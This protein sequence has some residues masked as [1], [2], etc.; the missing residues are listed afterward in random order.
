M[1]SHNPYHIGGGDAN[2][3]TILAP[4]SLGKNTPNLFGT[5]GSY[6]AIAKVTVPRYERHG[7][8]DDIDLGTATVYVG[9]QTDTLSANDNAQRY[10]HVIQ[11]SHGR[12][13][14]ADTDEVH[15]TLLLIVQPSELEFIDNT[16]LFPV[17]YD[18]V[19][20]DWASTIDIALPEG[21]VSDIPEIPADVTTGTIDTAQ[22][23]I[24]DVGS[25]WTATTITRNL[26]H[27]GKK[28][29]VTTEHP[30]VNHKG[31]NG[32]SGKK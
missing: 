13:H 23:T 30:M 17:V 5:S 20:G 21:F 7:G 12:V 18:S 15:G 16:V 26:I 2:V 31:G 27:K 6:L 11:D 28:I 10:H 32:N 19:D 8:H 9:A 24:T 14:C 4:A 29:K 1:D 22:F 3:Y 25:D